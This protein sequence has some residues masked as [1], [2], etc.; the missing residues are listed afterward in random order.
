LFF[1]VQSEIETWWR[2]SG[3]YVWPFGLWGR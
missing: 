2:N 1:A 3:D